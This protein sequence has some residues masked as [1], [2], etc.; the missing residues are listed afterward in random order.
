M[1]KFKAVFVMDTHCKFST[2]NKNKDHAH[3]GLTIE[4]SSRSALHPWRS[5]KSQRV[6]YVIEELYLNMN[7][8]LI[9]TFNFGFHKIIVAIIKTSHYNIRAWSPN[10]WNCCFF[11]Q[12][13]WVDYLSWFLIGWKR[14]DFQSYKRTL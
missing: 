12:S 14:W 7:K 2:S 8:L 4:K 13:D 11:S 9:N 3:N 5:C 1:K 6:Q 10:K